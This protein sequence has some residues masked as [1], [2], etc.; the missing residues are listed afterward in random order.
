MCSSVYTVLGRTGKWNGSTGP[1]K[2]SGP[3]GSP[4]EA[5]KNALTHSP[6]GSTTTTM[7]ATTPPSEA[8]PHQP[9]VTNLMAEYT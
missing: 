3:T 4:S 6:L 7:N 1:C 5:I 2:P 8:T 9:T